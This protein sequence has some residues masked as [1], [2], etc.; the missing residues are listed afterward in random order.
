M[1]S[2][3]TKQAAMLQTVQ[4]ILE[5]VSCLR[6]PRLCLGKATLT[7]AGHENLPTCIKVHKHNAIYKISE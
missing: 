4:E 3:D 5:W 1:F 7:A 2:A 6:H